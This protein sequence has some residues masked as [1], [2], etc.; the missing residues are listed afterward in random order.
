MEASRKNLNERRRKG[1]NMKKF[2]FVG[3]A[4]LGVLILCSACASE[5]K[6]EGMPKLY[7]CKIKLTQGS[8]P[9]EGATVICMA[10]DLALAR[11]TVGG[12][13][14]ASGTVDVVTLGKYKGAPQGT[15]AVTVVKYEN[16]WN[17]GH[18][19]EHDAPDATYLMVDQK[20]ETKETTPLKMTVETKTN[21]FEFDCGEPMRAEREKEAI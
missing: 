12:I 19:E 11:W 17:E 18:S 16:V 6:P 14:D 21:T 10:D 3:A 2:N 13:S 15:F 1:E 20:Y 4:F 7:P 9:L 8:A 5:K